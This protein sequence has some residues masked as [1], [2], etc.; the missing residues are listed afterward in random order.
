MF[1]RGL[2]VDL[3]N[4]ALTADNAELHDDVDQQIQ[5]RLYFRS[6]QVTTAGALLDEQRQL[7]E[8]EIRAGG[9]NA[10]DGAW[11]ARI[12]IAQVVERFIRAQLREQD[13]VRSHAQ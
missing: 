5:Q 2:I 3:L 6:G 1:A 4:A 9:V 12:R 13:P 7:F 10:R 8:G 11:M